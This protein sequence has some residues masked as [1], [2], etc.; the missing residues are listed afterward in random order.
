[1]SQQTEEA[2]L[3]DFKR[4]VVE[5]AQIAVALAHPLKADG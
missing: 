5:R 3:R 4:D 2:S 1:M